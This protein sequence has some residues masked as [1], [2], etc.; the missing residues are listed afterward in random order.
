MKV[1][2]T[3]AT[4]FV[5]NY[6]LKELAYRGHDI[7]LVTRDVEKAKSK[8]GI[9]HDAFKWDPAKEELPLEA[10]E[11]VD[12]V[13]HLLGENIAAGRWTNS[14]KDKIYN[15][16]IKGS[17]NLVSA[18]NKMGSSV[19]TLVSASAIGFY[20]I[21][22]EEELNEN[23]AKG[24]NWLSKVCHDWERE[25]LKASSQRT[26]ILRTGV[27]LGSGGGAMAKMMLPF[28]MGGGGILG[29]GKQFM[30]W[31]HV[32]DLA[33]IYVDAIEKESFEG[34][35][36]ATAPHS[37]TNH[38]F[39]KTLG[40]I[41][42]RPT[43]FPV[44]K[45]ALKVLFGEMSSILLDS[46]N[47]I[48]ER[49][50]KEGFKFQFENLPDALE[51]VCH[52][53]KLPPSTVKETHQIFEQYQWLPGERNEVFSFFGKPENLEK[54]TPEWVSF[55]IIDK[56]HEDVKEG[57]TFDYKLKI[58]GLTIIWKTV[59]ERFIPGEEFVDWQK[60]GPYDVWYHTHR[61]RDYKGGTLMEDQVYYRVPF[62]FIGELLLGAYIRK[63]IQKI[64]D[65]RRSAIE[66]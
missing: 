13:I 16:R 2:V 39:T 6:V 21:N 42:G 64:F 29:S 65:H 46:Q 43:L 53:K 55:K 15:S 28:K 32:K 30:S 8:I 41:L 7:V 11:G 4:G 59:I 22:T 37:L 24:S 36:N 56:S 26:V 47:V 38:T 23:S 35:Y 62:G 14:L 66:G 63:D 9:P 44:P 18:I 58:K 49:L 60:S 27:V 34:V 19:K 25:A 61:F 20:D 1:L 31:I 45:L 48:P 54:I 52:K 5:G 51:D 10:L 3:G 40:K 17:Q 33:S 12:S 50:V 57:A